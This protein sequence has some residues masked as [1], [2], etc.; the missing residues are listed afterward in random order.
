MVIARPTTSCGVLHDVVEDTNT[1]CV[2]LVDLLG[3]KIWREL[4]TLSRYMP[5]FDPVTGQ[6]IGRFKKSLE[7]YYVPITKASDGVKRTKCADRL[8]N[9]E[10]CDVWEAA[11]RGRYVKETEQYVLPIARTIQGSYAGELEAILAKIRVESPMDI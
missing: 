5:F 8:N 9:L 3:P 6:L 1:P 7:E 11:R 10:T 4:E 2:V